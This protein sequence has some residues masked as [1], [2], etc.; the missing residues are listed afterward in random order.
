MSKSISIKI[1]LIIAKQFF[2]ITQPIKWQAI[3]G[4]VNYSTTEELGRW[5]SKENYS[6]IR[7]N[8]RLVLKDERKISVICFTL[9]KPTKNDEVKNR[10]YLFG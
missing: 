1:T 2:S 8:E 9:G 6:F 10:R 5:I 7:N 3:D 4:L